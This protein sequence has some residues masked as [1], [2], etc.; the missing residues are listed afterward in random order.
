MFGLTTIG[1]IRV[2]AGS[3]GWLVI[4]G[5]ILSIVVKTLQK[6]RGSR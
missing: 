6:R 1:S 2:I 5:I 3:I 4:F